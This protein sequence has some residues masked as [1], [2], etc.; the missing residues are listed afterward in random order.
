MTTFHKTATAFLL[1][2]AL[3]LSG[4]AEQRSI[5]APGTE[6]NVS[7]DISNSNPIERVESSDST[8]TSSNITPEILDSNSISTDSEIKIKSFTAPDGSTFHYIDG[9]TLDNLTYSESDV[10]SFIAPDGNTLYYLD[11]TTLVCDHSYIRYAQPVFHNTIDEPGLVDWEKGCF[12]GE[13]YNEEWPDY[14]SAEIEDRNY[15]K[16]KAGDKLE[17]GL[18]VKS[19]ESHFCGGAIATSCVIFEGELTLTGLLYFDSEGISIAADPTQY[20][21][22]ISITDVGDGIYGYIDDEE[23]FAIICDGIGIG[24]G[25][26]NDL[27]FNLSS[28]FVS[29]KNQKAKVTIKDLT[30]LFGNG[31]FRRSSATLVSAEPIT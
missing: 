29:G 12:T 14:Y 25:N 13:Y 26:I 20:D 4:C 18:T 15:F 2:A 5:P 21:I 6:T 24:L 31:I 10:K 11:K 3:L 28:E 30:L 9:D 22:P 19:A 17:N 1:T 23:K 8:E 16:V 7:S 27:S